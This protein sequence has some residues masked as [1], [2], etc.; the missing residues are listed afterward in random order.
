KL[1][2]RRRA[3]S[4]INGRRIAGRHVQRAAV[5]LGERAG[6]DLAERNRGRHSGSGKRRS[7]APATSATGTTGRRANGNAG[8]GRIATV[9]VDLHRKVIRTLAAV[10]VRA[11]DGERPIAVR[12]NRAV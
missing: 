1:A 7:A 2:R 3:I 11:T 5:K 4:P 9:V 12:D 6:E 8:A 10:G